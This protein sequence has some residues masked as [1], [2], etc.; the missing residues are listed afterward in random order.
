MALSPSDALAELNHSSGLTWLMFGCLVVK[1]L[2]DNVLSDYLWLRAVILTNA[3]VA[4]VGL[5]LTIPLALVSDVVF[6]KQSTETIWS[7]GS[8]GGAI[9]VMTGFVLVNVGNQED[10]I[11][12]EPVSQSVATAA[13]VGDDPPSHRP[14][15][16]RTGGGELDETEISEGASDTQ[17]GDANNSSEA[18]MIV[19]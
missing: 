3:T 10:D 14:F 19:D 15:S 8:V 4:T 18:P 1:G 13:D 16:D 7:F 17:N 12:R 9:A 11:S 5:G 6:M 2:L